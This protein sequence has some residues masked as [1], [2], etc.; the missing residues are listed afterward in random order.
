VYKVRFVQV[1][2]LS[3]LAVWYLKV[4]ILTMN[5][6]VCVCVC[7]PKNCPCSVAACGEG[8]EGTVVHVICT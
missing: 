8:E 1:Q 3:V 4:A 6:C 2:E 5:V 7:P